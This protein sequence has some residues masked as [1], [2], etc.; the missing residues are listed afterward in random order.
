MGVCVMGEAHVVCLLLICYVF[1]SIGS[2]SFFDSYKIFI[3]K[4]NT[5]TTYIPLYRYPTTIPPLYTTGVPTT[6]IPRYS[7]SNYLKN[8]GGRGGGIEDGGG[9]LI[10]Y[11]LLQ[12]D[13]HYHF[14]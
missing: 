8:M 9:S 12:Y 1:F 7:T 13:F 14:T 5:P 4:I 10:I 3:I 11:Y 6:A 2:S